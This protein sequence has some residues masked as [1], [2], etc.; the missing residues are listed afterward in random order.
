MLNND[1]I[2]SRP[3][4]LIMIMLSTV[5]DCNF[6][7][8]KKKLQFTDGVLSVH[9]Q[10]LEEAGYVK[11]EK[12]FIGKRPNTDYKMTNSG[13]KALL[14]YIHEMEDLFSIVKNTL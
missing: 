1:I 11:I 14:E 10:K 5:A 13:I 8:L 6:S 2:H 12:S 9:M 4:L 7:F 3:R